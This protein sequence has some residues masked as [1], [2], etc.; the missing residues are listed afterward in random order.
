LDIDSERLEQ[1]F[2][3]TQERQDLMGDYYD[4]SWF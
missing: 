4:S 1:E 2:E 3:L